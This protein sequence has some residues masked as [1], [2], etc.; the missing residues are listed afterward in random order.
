MGRER[1]LTLHCRRPLVKE[2]QGIESGQS[3]K[4]KERNM[5]L[6]N[7]I[8]KPIVPVRDRPEVQRLTAELLGGARSDET[9]EALKDPID[10]LDEILERWD[11]L[12]SLQS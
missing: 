8:S 3:A 5:Y 4:T 10:H 6:K 9:R 2:E 12:L 1:Q 7:P 11:K